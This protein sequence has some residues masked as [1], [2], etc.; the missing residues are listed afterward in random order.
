MS[1]VSCYMSLKD[2]DPADHMINS[3]GVASFL[4]QGGPKVGNLPTVTVFFSKRLTQVFVQTW[5]K[6]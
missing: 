6:I 1:I 5:L 3:S 4:D 2:T